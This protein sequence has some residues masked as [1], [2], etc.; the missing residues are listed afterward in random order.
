MTFHSPMVHSYARLERQVQG[1]MGEVCGPFCR[2]CGKPCC[3][4]KFCRETITSPWLVLVRNSFPP[5]DRYDP[6]RGWRRSGGCLLREGRSPICYEYFCKKI[7]SDGDPIRNYALQT[8]GKL[9]SFAGQK[10]LNGIH[11]VAIPSAEDLARI[12]PERLFK[13]LQLAGT[14]FV[15]CRQVLK[16]NDWTPRH[17]A[18][19]ALV[20]KPSRSN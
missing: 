6:E 7:A 18:Q 13:R 19:M 5:E 16:K 9:L 15:A 11:L 3:Q 8:L 2:S 1:L 4:E 17:L 14:A 20:L 12:K 10:A